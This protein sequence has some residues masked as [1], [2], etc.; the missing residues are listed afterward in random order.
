MTEPDWNALLSNHDG[1]ELQAPASQV[2]LAHVEASLEAVLPADLRALYLVSNG[3]YD[4]SGGWYVIWPLAD[5]IGRNSGEWVGRETEPRRQFIGFGDDGTGDPFCVPR[6]GSHGVF[7]WHPI[8]Q[9]AVRLA[10]TVEAFWVGWN[11]GTI[12]T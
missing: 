12:A 6:N 1:M 7:I 3:V 9:E 2:A 11:G 10:D 5:M 4:K 8:G